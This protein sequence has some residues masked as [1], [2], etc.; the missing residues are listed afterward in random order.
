MML[1]INTIL[2]YVRNTASFWPLLLIVAVFGIGQ[3]AHL[4]SEVVY[5]EGQAA[6]FGF[7]GPAGEWV[8]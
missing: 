5:N 2:K 4:K 1:P 8:P 6:D 3:F 7:G